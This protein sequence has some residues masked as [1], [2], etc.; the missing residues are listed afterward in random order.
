MENPIKMD[1]LGVPL[2]LETRICYL[3]FPLSCGN[4]TQSYIPDHL[5]KKRTRH[6]CAILHKYEY[7]QKQPESNVQ[8]TRLTFHLYWLVDRDPYNRLL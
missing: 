8:K 2:F 5:A 4:P 3:T 7:H 1:D 6:T